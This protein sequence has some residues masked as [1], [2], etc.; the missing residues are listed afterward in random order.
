MP[1]T[2]KL[3]TAIKDIIE[4]VPYE[5]YPGYERQ[6][7]WHKSHS[8]E[9]FTQHAYRLA[10]LGMSLEEIETTLRDLYGAVAACYGDG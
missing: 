1:D 10:E 3:S 9:L 4:R 5:I 2:T 8:R 7:S 6:R